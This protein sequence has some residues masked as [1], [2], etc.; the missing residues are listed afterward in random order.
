V[1][2]EAGKTGR[3]AKNEVKN[4]QSKSETLQTSRFKQQMALKKLS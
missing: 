4:W 1:R 2:P 3:D